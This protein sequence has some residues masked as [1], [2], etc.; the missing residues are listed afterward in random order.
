MGVVVNAVT[1]AEDVVQG[2]VSRTMQGGQSSVSEIATAELLR[3]GTETKS[4]L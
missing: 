3:T 2:S 4:R 1:R